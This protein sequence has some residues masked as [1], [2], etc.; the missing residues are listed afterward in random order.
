[1]QRIFNFIRWVLYFDNPP[2]FYNI[3]DIENDYEKCN[4][5]ITMLNSEN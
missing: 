3:I 2:K 4:E 1:M 5:S